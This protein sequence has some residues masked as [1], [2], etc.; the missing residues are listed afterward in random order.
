MKQTNPKNTAF[1][2]LILFISMFIQ[3]E[4]FAQKSNEGIKISGS[5]VDQNGK[6]VKGAAIL[7]KGTTSGTATDLEGNFNLTVPSESSVL[8]VS[9]VDMK[10]EEVPVG[11]KKNFQITLE[12]EAKTREPQYQVSEDGYM[13]HN[14]IDQFPIPTN[15]VDEWKKYMAKNL[16]YPKSARN[17]KTQG[18][19]IVGF[20]VLEDGS[21]ANIEVIRGIGGEC[22]QEAV[23]IIAE[24]PKWNPGKKDEQAVVT[25]I[26]LPIRFVI[27]KDSGIATLNQREEK[28]IA[29]RFGKHVVVVGYQAD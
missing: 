28:A 13:V 19:V 25:Q 14:Q 11:K 23:R 21:V 16:T 5:V 8:V 27:A 29:D 22:D 9:F 3:N 2:I 24:G 1:L 10:S 18:T 7:I 15:G 6:I 4:S 12:T 17:A 26:S 20:K